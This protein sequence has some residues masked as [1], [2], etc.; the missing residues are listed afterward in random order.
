VIKTPI[1]NLEF[2]E[3][4]L[5]EFQL[6]VSSFSSLLWEDYFELYHVFLKLSAATQTSIQIY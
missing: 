5:L 4:L 3:D 2:S 1:A 6:L